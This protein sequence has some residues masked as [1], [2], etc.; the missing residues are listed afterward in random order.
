MKIKHC[1]S[2]AVTMLAIGLLA[3]PVISTG[4]NAEQNGDL[5]KLLKERRDTLQQIVE[6]VTEEY[7][8]GKKDFAPVVEAKNLTVTVDA[9][10]RDFTA[11]LKEMEARATDLANQVYDHP[12]A[13]E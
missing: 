2:V 10:H 9:A 11:V 7:H 3:L 4:Q 6:V 12:K 8:I 13:N 5:D 1:R